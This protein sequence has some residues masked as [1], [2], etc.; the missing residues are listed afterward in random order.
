MRHDTFHAV[1]LAIGVPAHLPYLL[2]YLGVGATVPVAVGFRSH[3]FV[4]GEF[5]DGLVHSIAL[6]PLYRQ[7]FPRIVDEYLSA[8]GKFHRVFD[9]NFDNRTGRPREVVAGKKSMRS[10]RRRLAIRPSRGS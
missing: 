3:L 7:Q 8:A 4:T 9:Y 1:P 2:E 5:A 6:H 10:A